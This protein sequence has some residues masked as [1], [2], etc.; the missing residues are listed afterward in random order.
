MDKWKPLGEDEGILKT[1]QV[2]QVYEFREPFW[3]LLQAF[4]VK[5]EK[6]RKKLTD[7]G[8]YWHSRILEDLTGR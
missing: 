3:Q 1:G 6:K 4:S 2:R 8:F 7:T 5:S